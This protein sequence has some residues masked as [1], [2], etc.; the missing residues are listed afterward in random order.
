[1]ALEYK[2]W[3][4][5]HEVLNRDDSESSKNDLWRVSAV[6]KRII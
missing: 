6:P 3:K 2:N 5:K 1:M 4:A